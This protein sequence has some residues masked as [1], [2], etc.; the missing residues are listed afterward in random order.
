MIDVIVD[1]GVDM[2]RMPDVAR[3]TSAAQAACAQAGVSG[4]Q[5][6]LCIRFAGDEAVRQLNHAWR[7]RDEVTDVLSFPMQ[8]GDI[9]AAA[10]LGDIALAV[11]YVEREAARLALPAADHALHLIVHG[12]LH[13]L[14]HDHMQDADTIRMQALERRILAGLGLHDPYPETAEERVHVE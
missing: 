11:P 8:E 7:G 14:G 1:E 6:D 9:D 5:P 13:L 4:V 12:V 2:G 3:A 10:Y